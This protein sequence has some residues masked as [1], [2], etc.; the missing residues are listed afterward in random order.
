MS[1]D[2]YERS[3][4]MNTEQNEQLHIDP[5]M[6]VLGLGY[7]ASLLLAIGWVATVVA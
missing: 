5:A 7:A 3:A 1:L 6:I 4:S 2:K